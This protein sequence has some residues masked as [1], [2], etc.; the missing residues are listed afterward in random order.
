MNSK[1]GQ[2]VIILGAGI[3]MLVLIKLM[4]DMSTSMSE[5]TRYVGSM[6]G[7]VA[8]MKTSMGKMNESIQRIET[9]MR[10][11]GQAITQ[12][13]EQFQ[14]W[15]PVDMMQQSVPGGQRR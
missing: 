1:Y 12:G 9:S 15:N 8:E 4:Y 5:M 10:G 14:Q 7:D 2:T 13:S 6:S 11:M 3:M